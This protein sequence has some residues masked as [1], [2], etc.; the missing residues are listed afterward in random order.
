M[1]CLLA[2]LWS[3]AF[4]LEFVLGVAIGP[5]GVRRDGSV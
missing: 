1:K 4:H 3:V 2:M 5:D